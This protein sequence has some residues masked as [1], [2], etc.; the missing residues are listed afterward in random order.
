VEEVTLDVPVFVPE[1]VNVCVTV[2]V[3]VMD[4]EIVLEV[5]LLAVIVLV[6]V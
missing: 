1:E 2:G 3:P 6:I 5:V 4:D